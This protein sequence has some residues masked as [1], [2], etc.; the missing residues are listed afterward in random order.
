M[1]IGVSTLGSIVLFSRRGN[2]HRFITYFLFNWIRQK[3]QLC[4]FAI[5]TISN[6]SVSVGT[7][8]C[9]IVVICNLRQT[10]PFAKL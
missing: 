3:G 1:M 8:G 4:Y 9:V 7:G 5:H 10:E 2:E 6:S